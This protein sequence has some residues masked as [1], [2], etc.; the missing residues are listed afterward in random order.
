MVTKSRRPLSFF[1]SLKSLMITPNSFLS[2]NHHKRSYLHNWGLSTKTF[3][4]ANVS[5]PLKSTSFQIIL[6]VNHFFLFPVFF[7]FFLQRS[8]FFWSWCLRVTLKF[9]Y[10]FELRRHKED[11]NNKKNLVHIALLNLMM[12]RSFKTIKA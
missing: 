6:V 11:K 2:P 5:I 9:I 8:T 10:E 1:F 12:W 3:N 7:S 4:L